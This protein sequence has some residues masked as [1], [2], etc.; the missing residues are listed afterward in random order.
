MFDRKPQNEH[1]NP[2]PPKKEKAFLDVQKKGSKTI[3]A[4][5]CSPPP[6]QAMLIMCFGLCFIYT[7][8][9]QVQLKMTIIAGI[10]TFFGNH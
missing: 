2:S 9:M 8:Y 7:L 1:R 6:W 5:L 10:W 3:Q 4:I